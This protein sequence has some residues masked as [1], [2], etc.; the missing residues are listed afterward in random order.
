VRSVV[1]LQVIA[2]YGEENKRNWAQGNVRTLDQEAMTRQHHNWDKYRLSDDT[3]HPQV[4]ENLY[5]KWEAKRLSKL[6][7]AHH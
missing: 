3:Q 2:R 5:T 6:F 7:Q 1:S 4:L